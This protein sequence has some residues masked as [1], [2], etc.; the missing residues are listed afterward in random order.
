MGITDH[1]LVFLGRDPFERRPRMM[2][3]FVAFGSTV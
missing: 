3:I 1:V 2:K